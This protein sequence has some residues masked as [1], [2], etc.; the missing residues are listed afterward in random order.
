[1]ERKLNL[2]MEINMIETKCEY[3]PNGNVSLEYQE[4]NN[5]FHGFVKKFYE[6]GIIESESF[7]VGGFING[8]RQVWNQD[9][10]RYIIR[11]TNTRNQHGPMIYFGYGS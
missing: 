4:K 8:V 7:Y 10:S 11:N 2:D 5:K 6:C 9:R 1:M 3:F